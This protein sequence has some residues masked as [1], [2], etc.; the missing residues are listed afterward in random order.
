MIAKKIMKV[1]CIVTMYLYNSSSMI[2]PGSMLS[3]KTAPP[4]I[5]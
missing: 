3:G 2:P 1:P 5:S 4:G